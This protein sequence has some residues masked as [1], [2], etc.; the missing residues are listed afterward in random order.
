MNCTKFNEMDY[1]EEQRKINLS[2]MQVS[3]R[4]GFIGNKEELYN[5]LNRITSYFFSC[6]GYKEDDY[7]FALYGAIC[8]NSSFWDFKFYVN[9]EIPSISKY[10][11]DNYIIPCFC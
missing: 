6:G 2:L 3:E 4:F 8:P 9:R 1:E 5:R 7:I 11:V 10:F